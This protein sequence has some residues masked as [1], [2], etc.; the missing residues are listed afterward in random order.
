MPKYLEAITNGADRQGTCPQKKGAS[1]NALG[2]RH[3]Y[4]AWL[5]E[6]GTPITVQQRAM[7]HGDIRVTMNYGEAIDEG[8]REASA[9]VAGQA[10]PQ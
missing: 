8:L 1:P 7:R 2:F 3:A 5:D 9:K 4:R 6:L 10:I